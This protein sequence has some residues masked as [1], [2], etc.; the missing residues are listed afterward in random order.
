M[1]HLQDSTCSDQSVAIN[2]GGS[3][4]N[5]VA[6]GTNGAVRVNHGVSA[7]ILKGN[8]YRTSLWMYLNHGAEK[9]EHDIWYVP[10]RVI[11]FSDT[12]DLAAFLAL[13]ASLAQRLAKHNYL[14]KAHLMQRANELL[15][16][17]Y[18]T[19]VFSHHL[20]ADHACNFTCCAG[21]G[22]PLV[23][24]LVTLKAWQPFHCPGHPGLRRGAS[25]R[26]CP[27]KTA[28]ALT[29]GATLSAPPIC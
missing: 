21:K 27:C 1:K 13:D 12:I 9:N 24:E 2:T 26:S 5:P 19:L 23:V 16:K 8:M 28:D 20:D 22:S 18:D 7:N 11:Q 6:Y 14:A 10:G 4:R 17:S 29:F 3:R 25:P 15:S